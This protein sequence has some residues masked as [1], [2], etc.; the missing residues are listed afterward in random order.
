MVAPRFPFV[1]DKLTLLD[2]SLG[3]S[4]CAL[5]ELYGHAG[6]PLIVSRPENR[7]RSVH[8]AQLTFCNERRQL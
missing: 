5:V 7:P 1:I 4:M 2:K 3:V 6:Y 8:A